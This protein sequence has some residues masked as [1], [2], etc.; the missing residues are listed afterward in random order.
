MMKRMLRRIIVIG[1]ILA[2]SLTVIG[3]NEAIDPLNLDPAFVVATVDSEEIT[4]RL[5][6]TEANLPYTLLQIKEANEG[7][8]ELL[9]SSQKGYDFL[10]EYKKRVLL[11]II[12]ARVLI[13]YAKE[14][15]VAINDQDV[16]GYVNTFLNELLASNNLSED[17]FEQ[18]IMTQGYESLNDYKIH[19]AL[20][21]K[22]TLANYGLMNQLFDDVNVNE[23]EIDE[24]IE[25]NPI[26]SEESNS[27]H[28]A[29]ILI[30]DPGKA[31]E[32][33]DMINRIGFSAAVIEYSQD[34]LTK[35]NNGDLGWI[36]RGIFPEFDKAFEKKPGDVFGPVKTEL[37]YHIIKVLGFSGGEFGEE[38]MRSEVRQQLKRQKQFTLWENWMRNE[39]PAIKDTY[40]IKMFF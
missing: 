7:F 11:R 5:L 3:Q 9:L 18:Y 10:Y 16:K 15:G 24:Y 17:E 6:D 4:A 23:S 27:V 31:S 29:H 22:L 13:D 38:N 36:E 20:Q 37:G 35:S 39:F 40:D 25:E 21:R 12:D 33:M 19:L 34:E 8:Y 14:N 26:D 2:T 28:L 30:N 32:I 1:L